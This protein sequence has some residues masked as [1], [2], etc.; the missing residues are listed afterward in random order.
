MPQQKKAPELINSPRNPRLQRVR[1]ALHTGAL[2]EGLLAIEGWHLIEE[3][4]RSP[5]VE[6]ESLL[7]TEAAHRR[8]RRLLDKEAVETGVTLVTEK[9]FGAIAVTETPQGVA[10]LVRLPKR[11]LLT[12]IRASRIALVLVGIQDPGNLGT[13]LRSA[14]AFGAGVCLLATGCV[15]PYNAKAVRASAGSVLRVP[16]FARL[17][18]EKTAETCK[19][20]GFRCVGLAAEAN[21]P[22]TKLKQSEKLALFVG[23]EARGLP[24]AIE[25]KMDAMVR[26]PLTGPVESLNAAM[27]ASLALYELSRRAE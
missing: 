22:V 9:A 24:P 23:G 12:T 11:E 19:A 15:S 7:A 21:T 2:T 14:E 5:G 25:K 17:A 16:V 13:I 8:L 1:R 26:I 27:A 4:L 3:A 18:L 20:A 6:F 10:A